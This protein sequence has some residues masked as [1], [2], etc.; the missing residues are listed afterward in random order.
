MLKIRS[1]ASFILVL[2]LA[3]LILTVGSSRPGQAGDWPQLLG[4]MRNGHAAN[5]KIDRSWPAAGPP[6]LWSYNLGGGFAGP[7]IEG[8]R[9][10]I[11]HRVGDD[12]RLEALAADTGD[13]LWKEDFPSTYQGGI[14]P[15]IGPRCVPLIHRG[16]VYAFGAAGSIH[17]VQLEDGKTRWSR[18]VYEEFKGD[19]GYFGAGSTPIVAANLLL[20]NVG[21]RD[22]AGIV[23]LNLENGK[24]EW[25][26]TSERASYSSPTLARLD[27][28]DVALFVTRM[29]LVGIDPKSGAVRFRHPFGKR[30][31]TVN[32]ATPLVFNQYVFLSASYRIGAVM[33]KLKPNSVEVVWNNDTTLSSQYNTS[34]YLDGYLYG[35]HGR[36]DGPA[37]E[38]RCIEAMSGRVMWSQRG[39]G[40]GHIILADST[41]LIL[42]SDG[43]LVL[44]S[45]TPKEF[46][47]LGSARPFSTTSR[48]LPALSRGRLF[49]RTNS[50]SDNSTLKCLR[51]GTVEQ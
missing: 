24:V 44:A 10:V 6:S 41:L 30:G 38:L 2:P 18:E 51:V 42:K 16:A 37:A 4:P 28:K 36:E 29:N 7:A 50:T 25:N 11:F 35:I 21:G 14:N 27:G 19:E 1:A 32:A 48:A 33:A 22:G 12:E 3:S 17:C 26:T 15:D 40:V 49:A 13:S 8:N 43:H 9:V 46:V 5:E 47:E 31:P 34:V 20:I 45:A 39:F 23:A